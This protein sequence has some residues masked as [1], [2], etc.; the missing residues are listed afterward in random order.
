MD[1]AGFGNLARLRVL[2]GWSQKELAEA[3]GVS[4]GE[5]S[6]LLKGSR[7]DPHA[8]TL[9]KLA[10]AFKVTHEVI[11]NRSLPL[12]QLRAALAH[13]ALTA[14]RGS[15]MSSPLADRLRV[16]ADHPD[17]PLAP[18]QWGALAR[19]IASLE[20]QDVVGRTSLRVRRRG[21]KHM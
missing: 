4:G 17:A 16:L 5:V 12:A 8:S 9:D 15:L 7:S 6:K 11:T 18:E 20:T 19:L 2:R 10:D 3:S 1:S 13:G 14:A 21:T